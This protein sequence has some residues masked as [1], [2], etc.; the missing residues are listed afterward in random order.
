[1]S[2]SKTINNLV[3]QKN[4][5]AISISNTVITTVNRNSLLDYEAIPHNLI[6]KH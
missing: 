1:M 6:K 4:K 3:K 5:I 2:R